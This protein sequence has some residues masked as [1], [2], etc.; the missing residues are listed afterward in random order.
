MHANPKPLFHHDICW[1][2]VIWDASL[3]TKWFLIDLDDASTI[4]TKP[5]MHLDQNSHPLMV[6]KNI[7]DTEVDIWGAGKLIVDAVVF[8]SDISPAMLA[9][10]K[11]M[12]IGEI[13]TAGQ[14]LD[15]LIH[16]S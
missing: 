5:A 14:A 2:N 1:P 16:L 8:L 10:G 3:C 7:H 13:I 6:F 11:R 15:E 4:P 9:V 12:M